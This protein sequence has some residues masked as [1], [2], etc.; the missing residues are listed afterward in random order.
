[1]KGFDVIVEML[2]NVN[3]MKDLELIG[4]GG[5][6]AVGFEY[7]DTKENDFDVMTMIKM[8][9]TMIIIKIMITTTK[10]V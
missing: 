3:L 2:A 7:S 8:M 4:V 5:R 9:N 10:I 1:M 6:L